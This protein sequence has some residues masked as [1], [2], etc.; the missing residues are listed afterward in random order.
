MANVRLPASPDESIDIVHTAMRS[1]AGD[2]ARIVCFPE[3]V[4]PGYRIGA[5]RPAPDP[6][7]LGRAWTAV[8]EHAAALRLGVVLGTERVRG[9]ELFITARV[10]H[11]D[12][13]LAGFQDKVQ[14]DP[15]EDS[16]YTPG[17]ERRVFQIGGLRFGVVICHEGWRY[18]ETVRWAAR[19]GAQLVFHP[20]VE[21]VEG[22]K[23]RW[24]AF[25]DPAN[26]FHEKAMLCRAAENTCYLA[27]VNCAIPGASTTSTLVDPEGE[28][29]AYQPYGE[30][31]VLVVE[32]DPSRA[33]RLLANRLRPDALRADFSQA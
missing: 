5:E 28:L 19:E 4:L 8:D 16:V 26:S 15:S 27:S 22:A 20:H 33:T 2:G 31:G 17:S 21:V 32:I 30:E 18:P 13:S 1:A 7:W 24:T 3:C 25:A 11:A 6:D 14:L 9:E 23:R 29:V 10:T 12:G